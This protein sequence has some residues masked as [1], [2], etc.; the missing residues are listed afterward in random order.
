MKLAVCIHCALEKI[1]SKGNLEDFELSKKDYNRIH[2]ISIILFDSDK[3]CG[4]PGFKAF[5]KIIP[6]TSHQSREI[7]LTL[8]DQ[9]KD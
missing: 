7:D 4:K 3:H 9:C 8:F 2:N 6:L 5:S 1:I